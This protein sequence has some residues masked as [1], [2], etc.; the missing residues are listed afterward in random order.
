MA[1]YSLIFQSHKLDLI[2]AIFPTKCYLFFNS[3]N[4]DDLWIVLFPEMLFF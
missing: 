3:A 2:Y 4:L 1:K